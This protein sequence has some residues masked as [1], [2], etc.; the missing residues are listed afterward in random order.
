MKQDSS[1]CRS[2]SQNNWLAGSWLHSYKLP[3]R[4]VAKL[5]VSTST[6][7]LYIIKVLRSLF[8]SLSDDDCLF[9]YTYKLGH[10]LFNGS[11]IWSKSYYF[12]SSPYPGQDSL[13]RVVIF[14]DM[15]KVLIMISGYQKNIK[16]FLLIV[17]MEVN[18]FICSFLRFSISMVNN[19]HQAASS[20]LCIVNSSILNS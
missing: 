2:T 3:K 1:F 17:V 16:A 12:K 20:K 7:K 9:R 15:G 14:G 5:T 8:L 18:K 6:N 11:Y 19:M 4:F 13:Q 10:R